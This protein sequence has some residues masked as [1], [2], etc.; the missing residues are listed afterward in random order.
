MRDFV[1]LKLATGNWN[2]NCA[3]TKSGIC[4]ATTNLSK[5]KLPL[6]AQLLLPQT[7]KLAIANLEFRCKNHLLLLS[8]QTTS[9][10]NFGPISFATMRALIFTAL[11]ISSMFD[12]TLGQAN[13]TIPD[14]NILCPVSSVRCGTH[15]CSRLII[16]HQ[17]YCANYSLS[18]CC[19]EGYVNADGI[20]C[21]PG[22]INCGGAC[23]SGRCYPE[24]I[25]K[26]Q[27]PVNVPPQ[28]RKRELCQRDDGCPDPRPI[29]IP[30]TR[31]ICINETATPVP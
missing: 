30:I 25:L 13:S 8:L 29:P 6:K 18:L 4:S 17:E 28:A 24:R 26:R 12:L 7:Y 21:L 27:E 31:W 23:C 19:L 15:C 2:F 20:C 9:L 5:T 16:D 11:I 22:Q 10:P 14:S 1:R 3:P